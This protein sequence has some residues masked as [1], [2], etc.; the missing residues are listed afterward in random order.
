MPNSRFQEDLAVETAS[1][2]K[3]RRLKPRLHKQS[4]P[5]RTE[6]SAVE[7]ESSVFV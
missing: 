4:P 7:T 3:T 6:D 1:T 5:P 2:L